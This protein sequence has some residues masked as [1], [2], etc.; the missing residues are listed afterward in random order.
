MSM[1]LVLHAGFHKTGTTSLQ[2]T[3][4]KNKRLLSRHWRVFTRLGQEPLCEAARA[5]SVRREPLER[6]LLA[7]E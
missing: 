1:R 6:A 3:L 2:Q 4:R 7:H 5:Y